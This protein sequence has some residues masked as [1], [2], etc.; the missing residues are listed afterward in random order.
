MQETSY[1]TLYL[2]AEPYQ[3]RDLK[4]DTFSRTCPVEARLL[5]K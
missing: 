2:K 5:I 3:M 1:D 4:Q